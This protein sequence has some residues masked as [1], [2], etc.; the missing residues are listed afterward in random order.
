MTLPELLTALRRL[1]PAQRATVLACARTIRAARAAGD[2][3]PAAEIAAHL[4]QPGA[5]RLVH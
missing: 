4:V 3:R 5:R 2:D 1:S